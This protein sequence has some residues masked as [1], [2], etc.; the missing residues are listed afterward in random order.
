MGNC[1]TGAASDNFVLT[2][3]TAPV[4]KV[5]ADAKCADA[6]HLGTPTDRTA[7][8]PKTL[9]DWPKP[10]LG[11]VFDYVRESLPAGVLVP[12][13]GSPPF[14]P[15]HLARVGR[16]LC[17]SD[18]GSHSVLVYAL[19][20]APA[21]PFVRAMGR[22]VD[23]RTQ[24]FVSLHAPDAMTAV[25]KGAVLM[26][27]TEAERRIGCIDLRAR[28]HPD[29]WRWGAPHDLSIG[30]VQALAVADG[31]LLMAHSR[32]IHMA[33]VSMTAAA[34]RSGPIAQD[35]DSL[36]HLKP[37]RALPLP[38]GLIPRSIAVAPPLV[39]GASDPLS[40]GDRVFTADACDPDARLAFGLCELRT[41]SD[42]PLTPPPPPDVRQPS[43]TA[44]AV[45]GDCLL[46]RQWQWGTACQ[47]LKFDLRTGKQRTPIDLDPACSPV[48]LLA[49][50]NVLLMV[51]HRT[52]DR[53]SEKTVILQPL[54]VFP[55]GE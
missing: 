45:W 34:E 42:S 19:D 39:P 37:L 2:A 51:C 27:A 49:V 13:N 41:A 28:D 12:R 11:L 20:M 46:A 54:P 29:R 43:L 33:A 10:L 36:I 4:L 18:F 55:R 30:L 26:V 22:A 47:V 50:D 6:K 24:Q 35:G 52:V 16:Y 31:V 53:S 1:S 17:V 40:G 21:L 48:S 32:G 38:A 23:S 44:L 15:S 3:A 8:M 14:V 5:A 9:Q 25:L 7:A